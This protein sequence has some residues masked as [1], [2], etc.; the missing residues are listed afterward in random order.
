MTAAKAHGAPSGPDETFFVVVSGPS[1]VGKST[2]IHALLERM[3]E[4]VFSVSA[5]TRPPRAGEADGQDYY[6]VDRAEFE[7]RI[8][9][10][11]FIEHAV[12]FDNL[13]GTPV[14]ELQKARRLGRHL[15]L[16][17]DVQGALQVHQ[18]FP[19]ALLI[20]LTAPLEVIHRRLSRRGTESAD[21]VARRFAEAERELSTARRSGVYDAEVVNDTVQRAVSEIEAIIRHQLEAMP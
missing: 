21:V 2:V 15:L 18:R 19:R 8:A 11:R 17:I 14:E 3:P 10:G 20:L 6:F 4:L 13:Y 12:V 7:Q 9:A 5:T 16:E 1:G